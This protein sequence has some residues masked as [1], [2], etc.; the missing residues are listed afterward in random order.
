MIKIEAVVRPERVNAVLE[1]MAEAGCTGFTYANVS[2]RGT[3][4]GVEVFTGRG[5]STANRVS[6]PKVVITAV[7]DKANQKVVVD[8]IM[9]AAKT[10]GDGQ[11][12]DGKIFISEIS[13][14][15]RVRTGD[16]GKT[17]L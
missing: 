8:A 5:S 15:I 2:G 9:K 13:D 10:S 11:I 17:A 12:G 3:Q 7:T 1:S 6:V 16:T 4:E 14:V